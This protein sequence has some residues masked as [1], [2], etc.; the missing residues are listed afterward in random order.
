MLQ[1]LT[2]GL[3]VLEYLSLVIQNSNLFKPI[4]LIWSLISSNFFQI[5]LLVS[6]KFS[7]EE[8]FGFAVENFVRI[9][10]C[11]AGWG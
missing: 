1:Q 4:I 11:I 10:I 3:R 7:H 8:G 6:C 2:S 5:D 9:C